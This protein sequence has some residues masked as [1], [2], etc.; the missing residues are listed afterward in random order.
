[1]HTFNTVFSMLHPLVDRLALSERE[2]I[3]MASTFGHQT[4]YG[5][6]LCL[7][8]LLGG[9]GVWPDVWD[10][11]EAARLI[12]AERVTFTM[13]A[14]PFLQDLS[15]TSAIER[16]DI[17][18]LRVFI[19]AGA[20]IPRALVQQARRRLRCVVSAGWGMTE[21]G[22]VTCTGLADAEEKVFGTDG[23]PLPDMELRVV[24]DAE[25]TLPSGTEG[26]LL[27]RALGVRRVP[28]APG[29]HWRRVHRRRLVPDGESGRPRR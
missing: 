23:G 28:S 17:S 24:D 15:S 19:S 5:Y 11:A 7:T 18:T 6:G 1:M 12:E 9:T 8:S 27:A 16:H 25:R 13:G 20:S 10:P 3:L 29:A 21:S 4:G 2:V 14:T 22:L 26:D